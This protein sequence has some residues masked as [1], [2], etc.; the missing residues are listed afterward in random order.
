MNIISI[1]LLLPLLFLFYSTIEII[2]KNPNHTENRLAAV[3]M[4]GLFAMFLSEFLQAVSPPEYTIAI[5]IYLK[6]PASF[7]AGGVSMMFHYLLAKRELRFSW[8]YSSAIPVV[9]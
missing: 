7:L 3:T 2:R 5:A 8:L 9:V 4:V 1:L 6:Y